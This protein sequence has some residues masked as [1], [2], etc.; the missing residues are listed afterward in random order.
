[1]VLTSLLLLAKLIFWLREKKGRK[2]EKAK[3]ETKIFD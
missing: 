2:W 3:E 1:M